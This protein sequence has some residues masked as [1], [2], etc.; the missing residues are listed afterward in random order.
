MTWTRTLLIPALKAPPPKI[1]RENKS[2]F[3][4]QVYIRPMNTWLSARPLKNFDTV[5]ALLRIVTGF[6]VL[7]HGWEVFDPALMADNAKWLTDLQF[8]APSWMAYLGKGAEF[9]G[10]VCLMAGLA[11]RFAA[12]PVILVMLAIAFGMG[13]GKVWYEDQHPFMFV[14]LGVLFLSGGAGKWSV[15]AIW[16]NRNAV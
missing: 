10:G 3:E 2:A 14:L 4:R 7:Y 8:P 13:H 11:T 12:I 5:Y 9:A 6:F 16:T 1:F 15:D